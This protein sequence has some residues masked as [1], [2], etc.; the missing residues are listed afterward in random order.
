MGVA[1]RKHYLDNVRWV[2]VLA[3]VLYHVIYMYNGQGIP[4]VLGKITDAEVQ[5]WDIFQYIVY[6]WIMP[7][8]FM[9]S[10]ICSRIYLDSHTHR[11]FLKSRTDR[12]LVPSTIGLF[13]FQFIQGYVNTALSGI[14]YNPEIP[15]VFRIAIFIMSGIGV[16]WYIQLLWVFSVLL[17]LIRKIEKDRLYNVCKKSGLAVLIALFV[18]VYGCAL[19][20]NTPI[21]VVYRVGLYLA[22]FLIGYFVLSHDEVI[23]VLKKYF[24]LFLA[25]ALAT[26]VA[27][28]TKYFG[29]VYSDAPVNRSLLY[30]A[31]AYFTSLAIIGG[32]ARFFDFSTPFTRWMSSRS[33][34]LYV[35]HYLGISAFA[36][37]VANSGVLPAW[38]VYVL[39][40]VSGLASGYGLY[41]VISRIPFYRWA[42]L[43]IRGCDIMKRKEIKQ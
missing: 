33:F 39:S 22:V 18:P 15:P 29:T 36:V 5:Y 34:G 40:L 2:T 42:V 30:V 41:A 14:L 26:T 19:I 12:L 23:E 24:F 31:D 16:L 32:F 17:I 4:G 28:C 1:M 21:M 8:L 3:V 37:Y 7:V 9:V 38:A 11:E 43:G 27:F 13:A 10:G 35:F 20:L 25:A 6:P